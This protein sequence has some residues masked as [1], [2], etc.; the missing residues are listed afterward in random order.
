[1]I[2]QEIITLK[3][4]VRDIQH[5]RNVLSFIKIIYAKGQCNIISIVLGGF[6]ER[7]KRVVFKSFKSPLKFPLVST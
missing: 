2:R 4:A 3:S 5:L 7:G 1:M 6:G